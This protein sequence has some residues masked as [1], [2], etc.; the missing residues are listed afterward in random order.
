[1]YHV[2]K[3]TVLPSTFF[4]IMIT[5]KDKTGVNSCRIFQVV[6]EAFQ[7]GK[8]RGKKW[9]KGKKKIGMGRKRRKIWKREEKLERG[10]KREEKMMAPTVILV[11]IVY[12][13]V[14]VLLNIVRT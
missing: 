14:D 13:K 2:H 1:M 8:K 5:D 7:D 6:G 4:I 12:Q 11:F 3:G 10:R 9:K